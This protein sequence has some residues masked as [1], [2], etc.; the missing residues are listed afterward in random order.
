MPAVPKLAHVARDF[1]AETPLTGC[2]FDP[3]GKFIY[4]TAQ[5][6]GIFRW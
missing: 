2:R 1:T 3:T 5:N 6:S 4:A